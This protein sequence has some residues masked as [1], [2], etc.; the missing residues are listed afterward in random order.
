MHAHAERKHTHCEPD[1]S[2]ACFTGH[3][4][5]HSRSHV[6]TC[7][8]WQL[9]VSF[10]L[11]STGICSVSFLMSL[12]VLLQLI[13]DGSKLSW[14]CMPHT[15]PP[16][17]AHTLTLFLLCAV[18]GKLTGQHTA[19][20]AKLGRLKLENGKPTFLSPRLNKRSKL[21]PPLKR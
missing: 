2:G 5:T 20:A 9:F 11:G 3:K 18:I 4:Q 15:H 13:C 8:H 12:H 21:F 14:P 16:S 17:H 1:D 6:C 10:S 7:S 19:A